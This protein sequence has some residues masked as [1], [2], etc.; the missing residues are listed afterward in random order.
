MSE[1]KTTETV[2]EA[3]E[4]LEPVAV[5][6]LEAQLHSEDE[7]VAQSAAKLLLEWKRG[8]PKQQIEQTTDQVTRIVYES[9]AWRPIETAEV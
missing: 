7:R 2:D 4:R 5:K 8:K 9:A 1:I 6:K 3:L